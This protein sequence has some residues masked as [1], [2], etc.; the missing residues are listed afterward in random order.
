MNAITGSS[1]SGNTDVAVFAKGGRDIRYEKLK[2]GEEAP[3]EF[4]YGFLDLDRAGIS[5]AMM[6]SAGAVPGLLGGAADIAE[7]AFIA[8]THFGVRPLSSRLR[9]PSF[10]NSKVVISYTDGFSLSLGLGLPRK[11]GRPIMMGGFHALSDLDQRVPTWARSSVQGLIRR[12]LQSLDHVFC[13]GAAD[14]EFAMERYGLEAERSSVVPFGIDTDFWRPMPEEPQEDFVIAVGQDPNRDYDLLAAAPGNHRTIIV[15]RRSVK[16]PAGAKHITVTAGDFFGSDSIS[17]QDLRKLY[18][19][20]RAVI[21]PLKDVYQP[22]GYSVTL[23]AMSCGRP[24]ILSDIRGLWTGIR[25]G[26]HC[27]LVPPGNAAK[28]GEAIDRVWTDRDFAKG[29]GEAARAKVLAEYRLEKN[30]EGAIALARRGLALWAG[31]QGQ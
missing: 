1:L 30:G 3:R 11:P 10:R 26:D 18:N 20:A 14:R 9:A 4:F 13:F 29:V 2:R 7:R 16:I 17:D 25:G 8:A 23:Q 21:V 28:L 19:R 5:A 12:A 6:S 24:V 15:T 22:T 27:V 31:R